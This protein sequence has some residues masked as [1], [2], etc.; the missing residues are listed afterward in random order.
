[1]QTD[2]VQLFIQA[3]KKM[4][5]RLPSPQY[6]VSDTFSCCLSDTPNL[7]YKLWIQN[8]PCTTHDSFD[9]MLAAA[10]ARSGELTFNT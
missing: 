1:M 5:E 10:D 8:K 9:A 3:W 6:E 4:T 7:F 2:P